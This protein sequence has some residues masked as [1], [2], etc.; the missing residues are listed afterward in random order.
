MDVDAFLATPIRGVDEA[1][2]AV[3]RAYG[4]F[5]AAGLGDEAD[6]EDGAD[7]DD[8]AD[9]DA[10]S[11]DGAAAAAARRPNEVLNVLAL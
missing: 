11:D 7:E 9:A 3:L 4:R 5:T 10:P 6:A 1:G 2:T 8:G